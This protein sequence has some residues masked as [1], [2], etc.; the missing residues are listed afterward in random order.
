[1]SLSV[2]SPFRDF[3]SCHFRKLSLTYTNLTIYM[4]AF[5][6]DKIGSLSGRLGSSFF[7]NILT[8]LF[9]VLSTLGLI[10]ISYIKQRSYLSIYDIISFNFQ[11]SKC[12]RFNDDIVQHLICYCEDNSQFREQLWDSI[13]KYHVYNEYISFVMLAHVNIIIFV[14]VSYYN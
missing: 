4:P 14:K 6:T 13:I 8:N 7:I 3:G 9:D 11:C 2:S 10:N 12:D 5:K 1:M